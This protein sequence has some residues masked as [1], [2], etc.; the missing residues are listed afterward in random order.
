MVYIFSD[1]YVT[2]G[3]KCSLID[4]LVIDKSN[5][6]KNTMLLALPDIAEKPKIQRN[7][8]LN[9]LLRI[10][11]LSSLQFNLSPVWTKILSAISGQ[12]NFVSVFILVS[13]RFLCK[14]FLVIEKWAIKNDL[15]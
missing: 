11:K 14:G 3:W 5:A 8:V 12:L 1:D 13:D 7:K 10:F 6:P 9:L 2:D 15:E 4:M